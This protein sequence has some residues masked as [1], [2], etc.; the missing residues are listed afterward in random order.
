MAIN[1]A[2][3]GQKPPA[4]IQIMDTKTNAKPPIMAITY[5]NE[6]AMMAQAF[7][8]IIIDTAGMVRKGVIDVGANKSW[9]LLNVNAVRLVWYM[10]KGTEGLQ[11]MRDEI[12]AENE[13]VMIPIQVQCLANPH[14][15]SESRQR[16]EISA[17]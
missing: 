12:H 14:S 15:T 13:G 11:K 5:Q 2:L 8:D 9:E 4:L 3:I 6:M 10:G 1:R 7:R 17:S 16:G